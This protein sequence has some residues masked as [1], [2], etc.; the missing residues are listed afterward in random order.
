MQR[1]NLFYFPR[2]ERT[3]ILLVTQGGEES[4]AYTFKEQAVAV[5]RQQGREGN[6]VETDQAPRMVLKS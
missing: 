2:E 6:C 5:V 1:G 3:S 4:V